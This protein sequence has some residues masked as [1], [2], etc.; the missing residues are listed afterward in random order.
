[1][2]SEPSTKGPQRSV[3]IGKYT[4]LVH[5]ATGGM[6][7]VYKAYD[8]EAKREVALKV[9]TPELAAMPVMIERFRREAKHALKLR[10]ENIVELFEFGETGGVYYLAME[11]IEGVDLQEYVVRKG[12]LDPEEALRIILQAAKALDHAHRQGIVHRDVKPS[13]FLVMRNPKGKLLVKMT[14]LGLSRETNAEEFR[15][16]RAG[17]TVGTVDYISP[18]QARDSGAADIRSDLYSLGCTWYHLLAGTAVFP[19]GGLAERLNKHLNVEPPDVRRANPRVSRATSAVPRRLL[20]KRP[21]DR[22]QTPAELLRDL[23]ALKNGGAPTGRRAVLL[24]LLDDEG[25][26]SAAAIRTTVLPAARTRMDRGGPRRSSAGNK[27]KTDPARRR[28]ASR[29]RLWYV[30]GGVAAALL[31]AAGLALALLPRPQSSAANSDQASH[32]VPPPPVPPPATPTPPQD[33]KPPQPHSPVNPSSDMPPDQPP[34]DKPHLPVLDPTAAPVDAVALRKE[35]EAPWAA[36]P[37][38]PADAPVFHVARAPSPPPPPAG[39]GGW[40]GGAGVRHAGRR[41]RRRPGRQ[42]RRPRDRRRRAAL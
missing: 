7:A 9:L 32:D 23:V 34:P 8:T 38:R 12:M 1:M 28:P 27:G 29:A 25:E 42:A 35:V 2:P 36:L 31:V 3:Q 41:R 37:A 40:G 13:N 24:G 11:F 15:V 4:V 18:E 19:D 26:D 33:V 21:A 30:L 17:T 6:G 5:L 10:H 20:A 14:D 39:G 22:Y 16:T